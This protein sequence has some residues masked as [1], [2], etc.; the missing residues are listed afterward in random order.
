MMKSAI[1]LDRDGTLNP[2]P[3]YISSPDNFHLYKET[4]P[5]L[6]LLGRTDFPLILV[7]N[8][9]G[10]GRGLIDIS[11]LEAIHNKLDH[12]LDEHGIVITAKYHCPH[13]L[14]ETCSCRKP[15]VG[16]FKKAE[17][18]HDIDL[19]K[20]YVIGDS[21]VDMV[22]AIRIGARAILVKTGNGI[23]VEAELLREGSSVHFIGDNLVDC[24]HHIIRREGL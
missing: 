22:A 14:K 16:M 15:Q 4:V 5:A 3:G 24:A 13:T 6:K 9:S 21:N 1:F 12:L 17:K 19:N 18:D 23:G 2:D 8:Q 11:S 7:T 20:S 10:I